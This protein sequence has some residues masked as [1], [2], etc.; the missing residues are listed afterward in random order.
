MGLICFDLDDTLLDSDKLHIFAFRKAFQKFKLPEIK[1]NEISK[2]FGASGTM[3]VRNLYP[4]LSEEEAHE[5]VLEHN[6]NVLNNINRIPIKTFKGVKKTLQELKKRGHKLGV[7]SNCT[8]KEIIKEL[9]V[10]GIDTKLFS[11]IV[12]NDDVKHSKP[13]PDEILKAEKL[14]HHKADFIVGDSPYD[15]IAGKKAGCKTIAVLTGHYN[16]ERIAQEKPDYIIKELKEI[17]EV[18]DNGKKN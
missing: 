9:E 4:Y 10:A 1:P 3:I 12:G 2:I 8:H 7:I 11:V 6:K 17:L 15:I 16:R 5:I 14:T 13:W 18:I